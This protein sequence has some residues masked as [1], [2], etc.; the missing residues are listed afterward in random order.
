MI[1]ESSISRG[2]GGSTAGAPAEGVDARVS[3]CRKCARRQSIEP[4]DRS[5]LPYISS[6]FPC[7]CSCG[8][9]WQSIFDWRFLQEVASVGRIIKGESPGETKRGGAQ[10][11][12]ARAVVAEDS[13]FVARV[14]EA[15]APVKWWK[16][17]VKQSAN[18]R[19]AREA[20]REEKRRC[21]WIDLF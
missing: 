17:K 5:L 9:P 8:R 13:R 20:S 4:I 11:E 21:S 18:S 10:G 3:L 6:V 2:A 19:S 15:I 12:E 7:A 14:F 16:T 1:E